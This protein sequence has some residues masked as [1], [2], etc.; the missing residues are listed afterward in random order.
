MRPDYAE[1]HTNRGIALRELN[2][3]EEALSCYERAIALEP[4]L[5]QAHTNR[6][7][8]LMDLKRIDEALASYERAIV[9]SSPDDAVAYNNRGIALASSQRLEEA[10]AH[11]EK[12]FAL[13]PDIDDLE[14]RRLHTKMYMCDWDRFNA[15][16]ARLISA[17]RNGKLNS[18]HFPLLAVLSSSEEQHR[19]AELWHAEKFSTAPI[20]VWQGE[21]YRHDRIRLAY[22]SADF[23]AHA[24]AHHRIRAY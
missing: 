3:F 1:A 23:H 15:D 17:V 8:V 16:V 12:A 2:R 5:T 6:G 7:N 20:P 14:G 22:L 9:L 18:P 11:Y 19:Y 4:E 10:L 13:N 21:Q 24:T